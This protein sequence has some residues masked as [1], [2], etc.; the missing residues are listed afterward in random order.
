MQTFNAHDQRERYLIHLLFITTVTR[1]VVRLPGMFS[2]LAIAC[3][4]FLWLGAGSSGLVPHMTMEDE[5][6]VEGQ[7]YDDLNQK[8]MLKCAQHEKRDTVRRGNTAF[9]SISMYPSRVSLLPAEPVTVDPS[10]QTAHIPPS[11]P[12]HQQN[13]I[14]RL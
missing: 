3:L 8:A 11:C 14:Y 7:Q 9:A 10:G 4:L 12:L 2:R 13:S 6:T 5:F 1:M